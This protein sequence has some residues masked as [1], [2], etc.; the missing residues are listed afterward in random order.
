MNIKDKI[1]NKTFFIA[2]IGINH[3]GDLDTA[4][5]LI[6]AAKF[7]GCDIVKFQ[8]RVPEICVPKDQW[9]IKKETPWGKIDYIDYKNRIEFGIK[10]YKEIDLFCK[11]IGI[12]WT[13]SCWDE[14]SVEF[15]KKFDIPFLKIPSA[16]ITN[17]DLLKSYKKTNLPLI[18]STGMS[19]E[20]EIETAFKFLGLENVLSILHCNSSYPCKYE[21]LNLLYI[22]TLKKHYP[23]TIIGYSGHE[24]GISPSIAAM[25]LGAKVIERH[26]TLDKSSWGT[27]QSSSIEPLGMARLIRDI[28]NI[29]K[30]L[31]EDKKI[32]YESEL[33]VMS[34]LRY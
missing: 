31:G 30:S 6:E 17:L 21:N 32:V 7:S 9:K 25:V 26:I 18:F 33:K 10:E 5:A 20:K 4:K 15:I 29:E 3:N 23:K 8:K 34:K 16:L 27:D 14:D 28:R 13:A 2:E 24:L 19:T 1:L 22:D 12:S 11:K